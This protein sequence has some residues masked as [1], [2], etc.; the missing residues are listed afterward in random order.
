MFNKVC[1]DIQLVNLHF[2]WSYHLR[3]FHDHSPTISARL[4]SSPRF[5]SFF[6]RLDLNIVTF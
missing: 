5:L 3:S 4:Q 2:D 1:V 6:F